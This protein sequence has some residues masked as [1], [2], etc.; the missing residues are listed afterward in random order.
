VE[1][2]KSP[3][4]QQD[5]RTTKLVL[6]YVTQ[7]RQIRRLRTLLVF[8]V[9]RSMVSVLIPQTGKVISLAGPPAVDNKKNNALAAF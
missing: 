7:N 4:T 3:F 2:R 5:P 9:E 8:G 6:V 1:S